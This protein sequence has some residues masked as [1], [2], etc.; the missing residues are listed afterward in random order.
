MEENQEDQISKLS[1]E[2][3]GAL[4]S[5]KGSIDLLLMDDSFP[6]KDRR[7]ILTIGK[8]NTEKV[9]QLINELAT[10]C[11]KGKE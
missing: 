9:I 6:T 5:I 8:N 2:I 11:R 1:H 3:K 7:E 4:T 10:E